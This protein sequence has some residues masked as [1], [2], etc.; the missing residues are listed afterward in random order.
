MTAD[1]EL[2]IDETCRDTFEQELDGWFGKDKWRLS[3]SSFGDCWDMSDFPKFVEADIYDDN[4][5]EDDDK[6]IGKVE[7]ES[8]FYVE[9]GIGGRY[10]ECEPKSI[11]LLWIK[12]EL[13]QLVKEK[14]DII[15]KEK[16]DK[17]K[18]QTIS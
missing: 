10:V 3:G 5:N 17:E 6:P 9:E 4:E 8:D 2:Y 13:R 7:I 16:E 15:K 1:G 11:K 12:D 14:L 18:W